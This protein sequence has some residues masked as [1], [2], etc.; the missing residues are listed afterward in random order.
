MKIVFVGGGQGAVT[1]LHHFATM[2]NIEVACVID[3][4]DDA[5]A[6]L[7]AKE[8]GINTCKNMEEI[9]ES[10]D[11]ELIIEL[12][13]VP[14]V[15]AQLLK[16]LRP[17]QEIMTAKGA[18]IMIDMISSQ[19]R[20]NAEAVDNISS[21]FNELTKML[22]KTIDNIDNALDKIRSVLREMQ[23]VTLNANVE[24]ARAG[25]AGKSFLVVVERMREMLTRT[26]EATNIIDSA[27]EDSHSALNDL[28]E[29]EE[30]LRV[31]FNA[32]SEK[33]LATAGRR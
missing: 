22:S 4:R 25:D 33:A 30:R 5:P 9:A 19:A 17:G 16:I 23:I 8:Q 7:L 29:A 21:Q 3:V 2:E 10:P 13:G 20:A 18:R 27:S 31:V 11:V 6:V 15:Q 14:K 12:T 32:S 24:A 1:L 26:E 28:I